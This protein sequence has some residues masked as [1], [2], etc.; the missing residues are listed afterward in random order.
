MKKVFFISLFLL[1]F[2]ACKREQGAN[3]KFASFLKTIPEL[4]LPFEAN[5]YTDLPSEL[6]PDT[7]FKAYYDENAHRVYG[8]VK[9][10]DSIYAVIYLMPG[11]NVFP[12]IITYTAAGKKIASLDMV[13]LPGGSD[14]YSAN[15]SSYM[16]MNKNFEIQII[17]TLRSFERDSL[18]VIIESSRDTSVTKE[19]YI[20]NTKGEIEIQLPLRCIV[21]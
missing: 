5:S 9:I 10:N 7:A 14:G 8:K 19:Y 11:D 21:K 2:F 4:K 18:A 6:Y 3:E 12:E 1:V 15:G 16:T 20:I 17:D 13:H